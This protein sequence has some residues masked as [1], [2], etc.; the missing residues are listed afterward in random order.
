MVSQ[1]NL[2]YVIIYTNTTVLHNPDH[3]NDWRN[4]D[5]AKHTLSIVIFNSKKPFILWWG[6]RK[7]PNKWKFT[8]NNVIKSILSGWNS[9]ALS[10][11]QW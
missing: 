3:T 9:N 8:V 7:L 11:I 6:K 4:K 1:Y 5:L 2:I 10:D